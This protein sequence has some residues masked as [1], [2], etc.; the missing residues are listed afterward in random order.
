MALHLK[1][2]SA[3]SDFYAQA[4]QA[5]SEAFDAESL[6]NLIGGE[7]VAGGVSRPHTV[8]VDGSQIIGAPAISAAEAQEAMALAVKQDK[9][10]SK[11]ALDERMSR[12]KRASSLLREQRDTIAGLLMWEI[13]K[14]WKL[15]CDDVDRCLDGVDWYLTQIERQIVGRVPLEGPVSNIASWNYPLSVLVHAELVQLLAGNAVVAKTPTQGGFHA[16]TLAHAMMARAGL[17]VT[18]V[19]G[20][21]SE[22]SEALIS[23]PEL[24]A[25]VF[26]GGRT[27][28]RKVA[29]RLA[30][31]RK[32]HVLE[33]EGLNAWGVWNFSQWEDLAG[34]VKKGFAYAKQR[35]TAYPR[36]V[37]QRRLLPEFLAVYFPAV[38]SLR[39]GHPC[40]VE[41]DDEA[42]PDLDF[43]PVIQQRKAESL[44][45]Q[46]DEAIST[47]GIP[48]LHADLSVGRFI[49]GQD[50]SA[51]AAPACVLAPPSAWSLHHAEP[52]GPLDSIVLVD[53][54][55]EFLSAMNVSNGALVASVA[56]DDMDFAER[57]TEEILAFKVGVNK[58]R[59]RGDREEVFGGRGGSW[60]GAFVGGDLLVDSMTNGDRPLYGNFPDGSRYPRT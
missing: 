1:P 3:W 21:G 59:S 11:V 35:C 25:L 12:V 13:G 23:S 7:W 58:P 4:R 5:A 39:F 36:Y 24:G 60:K 33:Q 41:S 51:Y 28:G 38:E 10:W 17:P 30:D 40:A 49:A 37:V 18:L 14:P 9:E 27:N 50:T 44:A 57:M 15:A 46:F 22:L 55:A 43:G 2:G 54:E 47:G 6:R 26:V 34:H 52:F 45:S 53:T 20:S 31:L 56:T 32:R 42:L 19:S 8:P 29:T 16:L 48:L